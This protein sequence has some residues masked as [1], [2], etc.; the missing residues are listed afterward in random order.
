MAEVELKFGKGK[1]G[2]RRLLW[3]TVVDS[4]CPGDVVAGGVRRPLVAA[5][6]SAVG[7][8]EFVVTC[9]GVQTEDE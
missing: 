9:P 2:K 3:A 5:G 8:R 7:E 4:A 6:Q 1:V